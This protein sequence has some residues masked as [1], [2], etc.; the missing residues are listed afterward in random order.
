MPV[1][2]IP[3]IPVTDVQLFAQFW[4]VRPPTCRRGCAFCPDPVFLL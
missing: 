1:E 4:T 2:Q 3:K